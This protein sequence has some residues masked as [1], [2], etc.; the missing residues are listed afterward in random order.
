MVFDS[1]MQRQIMGHFGTGV[2]L[3]TTRSGEDIWAMTANAVLSLSLDPPRI[4]VAVDR[5]NRMHTFLSKGKCFAVN[6]LTNKQKDISNRFATPGPK[7]F[8]DLALTT[9]Q[10]GAP[11]LDEALASLDCR[12]VEILS[13]GD[14]DM[15]IGE[16]VSGEVG[17]GQPLLFFCGKYVEMHTTQKTPPLWVWI[18]VLTIVAVT[19]LLSILWAC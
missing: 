4:L 19:G 1:Q 14:H 2:T 8:S 9:G 17:E 7:D 5:D 15:F 16:P 6:V 10:T 13:G 3:V 12:V 11:I 18:N